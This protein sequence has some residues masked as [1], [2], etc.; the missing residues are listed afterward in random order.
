MRHAHRLEYLFVGKTAIEP[1]AF[2]RDLPA[3]LKQVSLTGYGNAK[4]M[5][6]RTGSI[7]SGMLQPNTWRTFTRRLRIRIPER[8]ESNEVTV[9]GATR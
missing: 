4:T 5:D 6:S 8:Y 2:L 9:R 7:R 3:N 1:D